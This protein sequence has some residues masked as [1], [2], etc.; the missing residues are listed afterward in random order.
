MSGKHS[1]KKKKKKKKK[2]SQSGRNSSGIP[3]SHGGEQ[4]LIFAQNGS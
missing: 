4:G 3:P 1:R 2:P